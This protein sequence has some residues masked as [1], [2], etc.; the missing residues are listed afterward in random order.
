MSNTFKIK[1]QSSAEKDI[2][3]IESFHDTGFINYMIESNCSIISGRKGTGKT[4]LAKY[5]E[6][7]SRDY[8]ID[9]AYRIPIRDVSLTG[10]ENL[11]DHLN[12]IIFFIIIK[13]VLK[14]LKEKSFTDKSEKYWENFLIQNGLQDIA[15]YKSFTELKKNIKGGFSFSGKISTFLSSFG[16]GGKIEQESQL[17]K[18]FISDSPSSLIEALKE[19]LPENKNIYIFIDDISDYFDEGDMNKLGNDLVNLRELLFNLQNYNSNFY[20]AGK[21]LKFISLIRNDLFEFMDGS[22]N[23]KL[24]TDSI[25]IEWDEKSFASLLIR[26]LPYYQDKLD[27]SLEDPIEAIR[28]QFPDEI[29]SKTLANFGTNQHATKFY[30]YMISVSFNRPRDFLMFCYAMRERL[31]LK[32]V[33]TF[34]N[35]E[36]AEIEYS[37]YFTSELKDELSLVG[38]LLKYDFS[39]NNINELIELLSQRENFNISQLKTELGKYLDIRTKVGWSKIKRF[40][41]ELWRYGIVGLKEKQDKIIHFKYISKESVLDE[42]KFKE[43]LFFLH[44]GLWWFAEKKK[45]RNKEKD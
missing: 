22:N 19:S 44:R 14:L 15:D 9:L 35:I 40:I 21:G 43:Y 3:L 23:N 24:L 34:E 32:H 10:N 4:A 18:S 6:E 16:A 27:E 45:N 13:T 42:K 17:S 39:K 36:S 7:K 33:A 38:R 30:S 11:K 2:Y 20:D 8:D 1:Q 29:F 25:K 12:S 26:R 37:E 28:K 41:R 31:S 5:L